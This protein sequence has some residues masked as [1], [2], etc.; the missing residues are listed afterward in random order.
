MQSL[1][2]VEKSPRSTLPTRYDTKAKRVT[3]GSFLRKELPD[4]AEDRAENICQS[5][6][7]TVCRLSPAENGQRAAEFPLPCHFDRSEAES[8]N[9]PTLRGPPDMTPKQSALRQA[10]FP[11]RSCPIGLRNAENI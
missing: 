2:R 5:D 7:L 1:H 6:S 3:S 9:F 4:R 10:P 11:E 8:R